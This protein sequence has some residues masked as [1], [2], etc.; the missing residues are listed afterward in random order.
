MKDKGLI[1]TGL[2]L[3][4]AA[5]LAISG[6]T[7]PAQAS[8]ALPAEGNPTRG[9][10]LYDNWYGVLGVQ[11]AGRIPGGVSRATA[12]IIRA[13]MAPTGRAAGTLPVSRGCMPR[14]RI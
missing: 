10:M 8:L 11:A 4:L 3:L 5:I 14:S 2:S 13:K 12:G 6:A 9:A 1:I 7:R